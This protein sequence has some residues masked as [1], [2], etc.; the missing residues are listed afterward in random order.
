MSARI[1]RRGGAVIAATCV[2]PVAGSRCAI[3][4]HEPDEPVVQTQNEHGGP[5]ALFCRGCINT[6]AQVVTERPERD[7][8]RPRG[9]A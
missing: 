9:Q 1:E 8:P 2:R 7:A 6:L 4:N 5:F 3:C